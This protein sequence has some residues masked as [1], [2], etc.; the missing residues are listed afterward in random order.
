MHRIVAATLL[1]CGAVAEGSPTALKPNKTER[2]QF[3]AEVNALMRQGDYAKVEALAAELLE[4]DSRFSSGE[5]KL[6]ELYV[7]LTPRR[8]AEK[9]VEKRHIEWFQ[10]SPNSYLPKAG[11]SFV[12]V[13]RAGRARGTGWADT[14]T[15]EQW[16]KFDERLK[17]ADWWAEGALNDKP[18]DPQFFCYLIQLCTL[19]SCPRTTADALL[20]RAIALN[21]NYDGAYAAMAGYLL[22]RWHGS[23]DAFVEFAGAASDR[24]QTLGN[25]VYAR[26]ATVALLVDGRQDG[27]AVR[28]TY[29]RLDWGRIRAG[30]LELDRRYPDSAQ[31]YHLLAHFARVYED[32]ETARA[33]L[34]RL[35]REWDRDG[36]DYW[37]SESTFREAWDWA[38]G[39]SP[40][41][42]Q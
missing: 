22:P 9:T 18:R 13:T 40:V 41:A 2:L 24:S 17:E 21:P 34:L 32:K 20:A 15:P 29:P 4:N 16:K 1:L 38:F 39:S 7:T 11:L 12:A 10:Q 30:L 35:G 27:S 28:R 6:E 37:F 5:S 23:P 42:V 8:G 3:R 26:V 25:I 36:P 14:V 31:T 19:K 33:A